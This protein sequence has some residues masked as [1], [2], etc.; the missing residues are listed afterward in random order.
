VAGVISFPSDGSLYA[1]EKGSG[2]WRGSQRLSVSRHA[3][4]SSSSVAVDSMLRPEVEKRLRVVGVL[5]ERAFN[6]RMV[7][8]SARVLTWV[9]EG[10]LDGVIEFDDKPWDFAAGA[11]MVEEAGG[12]F[13]T[14]Q[15]APVPYA[16][17]DWVAANPA[18]HEELRAVACAGNGL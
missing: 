9:A 15:N 13:T 6:I 7:G 5:A 2:T 8:S 18:L 3:E 1:A 12:K 10:T 14:F 17:S 4:L 11:V 16:S